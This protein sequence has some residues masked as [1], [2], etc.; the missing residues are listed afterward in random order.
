[1]DNLIEKIG[2]AVDLLQMDVQGFE[3]NVLWGAQ[4]ALKRHS[5]KRFLIG[6]HTKKLHN[7]CISIL[8]QHGYYVHVDRFETIEQPDG[9]I[10][11]ALDK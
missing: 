6:T 5:I 2:C 10:L 1:L 11:A 4:K 9:I 8:K 7:E 3:V